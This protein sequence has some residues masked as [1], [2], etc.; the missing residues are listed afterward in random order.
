MVAT[1]SK[2][3]LARVKGALAALD[4]LAGGQADLA[5]AIMSTDEE[6]RQ[7]H[8]ALIQILE[9]TD[10]GD[11]F[12][13]CRVE[14][15]QAC[16]GGDYVRL[17]ESLAQYMPSMKA[18]E[19]RAL[20]DWEQMQPWRDKVRQAKSN[21]AHLQGRLY[22]LLEYGIKIPEGI[23]LEVALEE[24][25]K[26][27]G[28][29]EEQAQS[30]LQQQAELV[31]QRRERMQLFHREQ[32]WRK[33]VHRFG[34]LLGLGR[35]ALFAVWLKILEA[36]ESEMRAVC[37][38][39]VRVLEETKSMHA[40]ARRELENATG[41]ITFLSQMKGRS[42]TDE[43]LRAEEYEASL[44]LRLI[45][46]SIDALKPKTDEALQLRLGWQ[47]AVGA[48]KIAR[49]LSATEY[50][51]LVELSSMEEQL[52]Q[53]QDAANDIEPARSEKVRG[54]MRTDRECV[55][56]NIYLLLVLVDGTVCSSECT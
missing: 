54:E 8:D 50:G 40:S 6:V 1:A 12:K 7:A 43:M 9:Q 11:V 42:L 24:Q 30:L 15:Y 14:W 46:K 17:H 27:W 18:A 28:E 3:K 36:E 51:G 35:E 55:E 26:A 21:L 45:S 32:G 44:S 39:R 16:A 23:D 4:S 25:R 33:A 19:A 10:G 34:G 49:L 20:S 22:A 41:A 5:E 53:A 38:A 2:Y 29:E 13:R 48:H 47:S 56:H 37:K 31:S 52:K